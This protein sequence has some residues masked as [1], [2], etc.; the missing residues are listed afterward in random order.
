[1]NRGMTIGWGSVMEPIQRCYSLSSLQEIISSHPGC[2]FAIFLINDLPVTRIG[3]SNPR[4]LKID[5]VIVNTFLSFNFSKPG[6]S[7][8][9]HQLSPTIFQ[10]NPS[11]FELS[12]WSSDNGSFQYES[13]AAKRQGNE[14]LILVRLHPFSHKTLTKPCKV[15]VSSLTV[16]N[17][18]R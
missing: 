17:D 7:S 3:D 5:I 8:W 6:N 4:G 16:S 14:V 10:S 11:V 18:S 15:E 1:M 9:N 12:T 2:A 13:S